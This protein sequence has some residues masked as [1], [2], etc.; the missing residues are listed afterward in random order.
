[1]LQEENYF[2]EKEKKMIDFVHQVESFYSESFQE[3]KETQ[4]LS[5]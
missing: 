5:R 3:N 2:S 1:M 4:S